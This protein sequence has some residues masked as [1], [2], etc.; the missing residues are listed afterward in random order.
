MLAHFLFLSY[1][2]YKGEADQRDD[3][4]VY[5]KKLYA[6]T[7][8][9]HFDIYVENDQLCISGK[10]NIINPDFIGFLS[11]GNEYVDDSLVLVE[12]VFEKEYILK[13]FLFKAGL[14]EFIDHI[15]KNIN[16]FRSNKTTDYFLF[17]NQHDA[18]IHQRYV[19]GNL[20]MLNVP[21]MAIKLAVSNHPVSFCSMLV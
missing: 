6:S 21:E 3:Y 11:V 18:G 13:A 14:T 2:T 4:S 17:I 5:K 1:Q 16:V 15:R 7:L 20:T 10:A 12:N 8:L 19:D 9:K